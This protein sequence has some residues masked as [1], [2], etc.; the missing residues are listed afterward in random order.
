MRAISLAIPFVAAGMLFAQTAP[1]QQATPSQK[2]TPPATNHHER[3]WMMR[4]LT[5]RLNLTPDQQTKAHAIF[6][7][8]RQETQALRPQL[9]TERQGLLSAVKSDSTS[10]V[11]R[12]TRQDAELN[13]K[14]RAIHTRSLAEFYAVL[15]PAQKSKFDQHLDRMFGQGRM[16]ARRHRMGGQAQTQ[17]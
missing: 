1:A 9:R 13:A 3:N 4:R 15:T 7:K 12:L 6:H 11:D 2:A 16:Q 17:G 10:Q 14:V 5:A 8:A